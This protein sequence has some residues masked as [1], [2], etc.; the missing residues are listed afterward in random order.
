MKNIFAILFFPIFILAQSSTLQKIDSLESG[1]EIDTLIVYSATDSIEYSFKKKSMLLFGKSAVSQGALNLKSEIIQIDWET[2]SLLAKGKIDSTK[3]QS[4]SLKHRYIGLPIMNDGGDEYKGFNISY[5]FKTKKGK[6][7]LG[8]TEQEQGYYHGQQIK[9]IDQKVLFVANGRYTT[10]DDPYPH[11]YFYSPQ[12]KITLRDKII[13]RPIYLYIADIPVFALPFGVFPNETGRRSGLI[14]PTYGEHWQRGRYISH[15]GYYWAPNDYFDVNFLTDYYSR[16]GFRAYSDLHYSLRYNFSGRIFLDYS[17]IKIG[18]DIDFDKRDEENYRVNLQ[19]YQQISPNSRIDVDFTFASNNSYKTSNTYEDLLRQEIYSNATFNKTFDGTSN[20]LNINISRRQD[21][22]TGNI[23]ATLPSLSFSVPQIY[24]FKKDRK[25]RGLNLV[26]FEQSWY[27]YIGASYNTRFLRFD[28]KTFVSENNFLKNNKYGMEH[29]FSLNASPKFKHITLTPYFSYS[30]KW[31]DHSILIDSVNKNNNPIITD[32]KNFSAIRTFGG[33]V[34]ASTRLYGMLNLPI[35]NFGGFRHTLSPSISYFYQPDFSKSN[36]DY[37]RTYKDT[38]GVI[39][40]YNRFENEIFGGAPMG[41]SQS[42]SLNVNNLF[43]MKTFSDDSLRKENKYQLLNLSASL[44]YNF[45]ATE[46]KL[47]DLNL[48]FRTDFAQIVSFSGGTNFRFYDYENNRRVNKFLWNEKKR[49]ADLT[50]INFSISTSLRGEKSKKTQSVIDS[51]RVVES[52][53]K[54]LRGYRTLYENDPPDFSIPWNLSLSFY[55]SQNQENPNQKYR[56]ANLSGNLS[57]NLTEQW[58]INAS[59][60]YDL[61]SKVFAAP[62]IT[63]YRD[64]HCWEM[65]FSWTPSGYLKGYRFEIRV[66]A[67]HLQDVKLTKQETEIGYY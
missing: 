34:S 6:V 65:N 19:H 12:M 46:Y 7:V 15:L 11:F 47:S 42:I 43:E 22:R 45:A 57:F 63:V 35:K 5:N 10:C 67:P 53:E 61:V 50:N 39:K 21:L 49:I 9:K 8:D 30:E 28:N 25:S 36:F 54:K 41:E 48:N 31:Y 1:D 55:F 2:N 58:K 27:E 17:R 32:V 29:N 16:G 51:L 20:S 38:N 24:P 4:D 62:F 59:T 52:N 40:K 14:A 26:E 56:N 18:E 64:L 44:F 37:F 60:S 13:A 3:I 23:Y 33:G 66:K